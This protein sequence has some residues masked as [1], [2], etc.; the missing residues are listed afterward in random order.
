[1]VACGSL[2]STTRLGLRILDYI[3]QILNL[4]PAARHIPTPSSILFTLQSLYRYQKADLDVVLF[5]NLPPSRQSHTS[6]RLRRTSSVISPTY[7]LAYRP[8]HTSH[9]TCQ[10]SFGTLTTRYT[11]P[12]RTTISHANHCHD[13][14]PSVTSWSTSTLSSSPWTPSDSCVNWDHSWLYHQ[15]TTGTSST[16]TRS[17]FGTGGPDIP[18]PSPPY[19]L[20]NSSP[21][22]THSRC[23]PLHAVPRRNPLSHKNPIVSPCYRPQLCPQQV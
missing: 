20:A 4:D 13:V 8:I 15:R 3:S 14:S 18:T 1:M 16:T 22:V 5:T 12:T 21:A 6:T 7:T 11:K 9:L 17:S 2:F 23:T 10:S 19:T